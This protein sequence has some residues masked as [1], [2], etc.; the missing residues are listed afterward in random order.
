[1]HSNRKFAAA[2]AIVIAAGLLAGVS[3]RASAE[4]IDADDL[5]ASSSFFVSEQVNAFTLLSD[6]NESNQHMHYGSWLAG[7]NTDLTAPDVIGDEWIWIDL[8]AEFNPGLVNFWNYHEVVPEF[9]DVE[10]S[11]RSVRDYG[12]YVA[13]DGT[14]PPVGVNINSPPNPTYN[15]LA[16]PFTAA[17]GWTLV[18]DSVT[19]NVL[20]R[21]PAT[22]E[23]NA[24]DSLDPTDFF[25][26]SGHSGV[27]YIGLDINSNYGGGFVGAAQIQVT[28]ET[29]LYFDA[30]FDE[31]FDVDG[32]DAIAWQRGL[33]IAA[34]N[35]TKA[36]GDANGDMAVTAADL[37]ILQT[38]LGSKGVAGTI[39]PV[40]G[41]VASI[42]EPATS[43]LV[44]I[45]GLLALMLGTLRQRCIRNV[46]LPFCTLLLVVAATAVE[47]QTIDLKLDLVFNDVMDIESGGTFRLAALSS[48]GGI[49]ALVTRID[50]LDLDLPT[51]PT[52]NSPVTL[53]WINPSILPRSG[54]SVTEFLLFQDPASAVFSV[55]HGAG[56]PGDQGADPLGDGFDNAALLA[57]GSFST[58]QIPTFFN[59]SGLE[60]S[61]SV[62]QAVANTT[63][64]PAPVT[65]MVRA[66]LMLPAPPGDF[67]EDGDIDG[68]DFLVWQQGGSP[69]PL[70]ASDLA[71]W[72]ANFGTGVSLMAISTAVPEPATSAFVVSGLFALILVTRRQ[73]RIY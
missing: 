6:L 1:M 30:D 32:D 44:V 8:G 26:L 53:G 66:N 64:L 47:A 58:G 18:Q 39:A 50:G 15:P 27:R 9:L 41:A 63:I 12:L 5:Q 14:T 25:D 48:G 45:G 23:P 19:S 61:G 46:M 13:G 60:T 38:Q 54:G 34:P 62:Y 65:T 21:G 17:D 71:D 59:F 37:A 51:T 4:V 52:L 68:H 7:D 36:D 16:T 67:D 3:S 40:A 69:D 24:T 20:E 29:P 72:E 49:S 28:D 42:P 2:L 56:T 70:S 43:A 22:L 10:T 35:A 73:R 55:G 31:D 57:T 11:G 33:G